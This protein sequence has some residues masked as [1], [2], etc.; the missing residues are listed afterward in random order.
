MTLSVVPELYADESLDSFV[1]HLCE[2]HLCTPRQLFSAINVSESPSSGSPLGRR[3]TDAAVQELSRL[4]AVDEQRL[5]DATTARFARAGLQL[6]NGVGRAGD[7][8]WSFPGHVAFCPECLAQNDLR[9]NISWYLRWT[10]VCVAHSA[11]LVDECPACG[12][13]PRTT[14]TFHPRRPGQLTTMWRIRSCPTSCCS[15]SLA[16]ATATHIDLTS[17]AAKQ[18]S[19]LTTVIEEGGARCEYA[20]GEYLSATTILR[21][22]TLLTRHALHAMIPATQRIP[23]ALDPETPVVPTAWIPDEQ[24]H[25][26]QSLR[27][28][29]RTTFLVAQTAAIDTLRTR[30]SVDQCESWIAPERAATM[31]GVARRRTAGPVSNALL[32]VIDLHRGVNHFHPKL[33]SH[34]STGRRRTQH[35]YRTFTLGSTRSID[36]QTLPSTIWPIVTLSA[37]PMP[38]RVQRVFPQLAPIALALF[39]RRAAMSTLANTFQFE[40]S[41]DA[42]RFAL[43]NLIVHDRGSDTYTYIATLHEHLQTHPAPIDYRRRRLL[44][45]HPSDVGRNHMRELARISDLYLTNAFRWKINRYVWQLL[46]GNDPFFTRGTQLLHG[47][48]AYSYRA[49][50]TTM[51][52]EL[53]QAA[54]QVAQRLLLKERIGEPVTYSPIQ[55]PGGLWAPGTGSHFLDTSHRTDLRQTSRSLEHAVAAA[56][57]SEEL[58]HI[59]L[60]GHALLAQRLLRFSET[61]DLP[62]IGAAASAAGTSRHQMAKETSF[63]EMALDEPLFTRDSPNTAT[64][65]LTSIGTELRILVDSNV[66]QLRSASNS[67]GSAFA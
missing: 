34:D 38:P 23:A 14:A 48:A 11:I 53:E 47:P 2:L 43:S 61:A 3:I 42:L 19:W 66:D 57:E 33:V 52:F 5:L 50:L 55:G 6:K 17:H 27:K 37:P 26:S 22:L 12:N 30:W 44:W 40:I 36:A 62:S 10:N 24:A 46:T 41:D 21:D 67:G 20:E 49:F 4:T 7:D 13:R 15:E 39:G 56:G 51:P 35:A 45:P 28:V 1:E 25:Y 60:S 64:R 59:A 29:P 63:L 54:G 65:R 31:S 8:A 32:R 58:L 16:E 18:E 9:W